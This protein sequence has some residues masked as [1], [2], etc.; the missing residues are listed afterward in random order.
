ML[1][2]HPLTVS[3]LTAPCFSSMEFCAGVSTLRSR[4]GHV[5]APGQ[6]ECCILSHSDW[7]G[8]RGHVTNPSQCMSDPGLYT[9]GN[10][11][12]F[13]FRLGAIIILTFYCWSLS[14]YHEVKICLRIK[15]AQRGKAETLR[16]VVLIMSFTLPHPVSR[17]AYIFL[18]FL[19]T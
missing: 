3:L 15:P 9:D 17:Y 8:E 7:F 18:D 5:M 4:K 14:S 6:T 13:L 10:E 16:A 2:Q 1:T 11:K 19:V 12:P